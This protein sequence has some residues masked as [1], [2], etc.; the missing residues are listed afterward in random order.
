MKV[1]CVR[2]STVSGLVEELIVQTQ[3]EKP[4]LNLTEDQITI[5]KCSMTE[6]FLRLD[7]DHI[8][9]LSRR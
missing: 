1:D 7:A 4:S 3:K 9:G 5:L 8:A 6:K 2:V